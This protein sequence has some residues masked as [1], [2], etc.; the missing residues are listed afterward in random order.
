MTSHN[1][2]TFLIPMQYRTDVYDWWA[3]LW[4]AMIQ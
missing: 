1:R 3:I 2:D 4:Q